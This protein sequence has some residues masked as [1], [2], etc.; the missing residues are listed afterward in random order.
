MKKN[1]T[2]KVVLLSVIFAF[3]ANIFFGRFIIAKLSTWSVLSSFKILSPQ[4][5]IVI[6]TKEE[7]RVNETGDAVRIMNS[8]K[9]KVSSVVFK[10][11]NSL[12]FLGTAINLTSD[13]L[14]ITVD[15]VIDKFKINGLL[16]KLNNGE[17]GEVSEI[18]KDPATDLVVLKMKMKD[19]PVVEFGDSKK[20][21]VG[22]RLIGLIA[23]LNNGFA[24]FDN[25]F[26][27]KQEA[28]FGRDVYNS[29]YSTRSFAVSGIGQKQAG[30][31]LFDNKSKVVGI[32]DGMQVIPS[33]I[34]RIFTRKV[35]SDG[36]KI[37]RP[38]FG[39]TYRPLNFMEVKELNLQNKVR[40]VTVKAATP[41]SL[42]GLKAGDIIISVNGQ[43]ITKENSLE[44]LLEG[45]NAGDKAAFKI[46]RKGKELD[47]ELEAGS[48]K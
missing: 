12:D 17:Y 35:L 46:I 7:V 27:K 10:N 30:S 48:L 28:D 44:E 18:I 42:A 6:N 1:Y 5:P 4:A 20:L 19:M 11:K 21:Q 13:G 24:E 15:S 14:V 38:S 2:W 25:A 47:L 23:D 34:M 39:F 31:V 40:V 41:A 36:N 37:L 16:V 26:V 9:T 45:L 32:W 29:D 33:N 43:T 22:E 8:V 3:L